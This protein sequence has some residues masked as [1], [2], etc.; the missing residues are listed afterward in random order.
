MTDKKYILQATSEGQLTLLGSE[1]SVLLDGADNIVQND[2]NK[3]LVRFYEYL[4]EFTPSQFE[5]AF[6]QASDTFAHL[7]K[8]CGKDTAIRLKVREWVDDSHEIAILYSDEF[9][10]WRFS[11]L[12]S[13]IKKYDLEPDENGGLDLYVKQIDRNQFARVTPESPSGKLATGECALTAE[14]VLKELDGHETEPVNVRICDIKSNFIIVSYKGFTQKVTL[15]DLY[16]PRSDKKQNLDEYRPLLGKEIPMFY[17]IK[18][19]K[20]YFSEMRLFN[21]EQPSDTPLNNIQVG[22]TVE[23]YPIAYKMNLGVFVWLNQKCLSLLH[24]FDCNGLKWWSL[25]MKFPLGVKQTFIVKQILKT[26]QEI[27]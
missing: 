9:P 21:R 24:V 6:E 1:T 27:L 13:M 12:S 15:D 10:K 26:I 23:G 4:P 5:Q 2:D 3:R 8:L 25:R 20:P 19:N 16:F 17:F 7:Q 22:D 11:L 14:E 18:Y